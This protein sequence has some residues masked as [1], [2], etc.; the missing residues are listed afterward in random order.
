V[1]LA[2]LDL[3]NEI[4]TL[5]CAGKAKRRRRFG[6]EARKKVKNP[7]RCRASLVTALQ[8]TSLRIRP[9]HPSIVLLL[10]IGVALFY[11]VW[12][13][14]R[15]GGRN[16]ENQYLNVVPIVVP[17]VSFLLDRAEQIHQ[18]RIARLVIH[19]LV[20]GT[21]MMRVV[22]N[23]PFVSGHT[24]FLSYAIL[25]P[26]SRVTRITASLVMLDV[27]YLKYFVWH[28]PI[29]SSAGIVLGTIA[30]LIA[31]RFGKRVEEEQRLAA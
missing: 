16:L 24:L 26:A 30:A 12:V 9:F 2:P 29:T 10:S 21:S 3:C 31:R 23:V 8:K 1:G 19:L 13:T 22:G 27:I 11:A 5:E 20:V 14:W 25:G 18:L 15:F 7:K 4:A 6:Y 28:D 17:F